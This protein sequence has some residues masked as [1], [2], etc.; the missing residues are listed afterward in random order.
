MRHNTVS[1]FAILRPV[2][3]VA[4]G[5]SGVSLKPRDP[6]S[7]AKARPI[8]LTIAVQLDVALAQVF[9]ALQRLCRQS[10]LAEIHPILTPVRPASEIFLAVVIEHLTQIMPRLLGALFMALTFIS[11]RG[12]TTAALISEDCFNLLTESRKF[13]SRSF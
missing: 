10:I 13:A 7:V 11:E 4:K 1:H 6:T 3:L 9:E 12:D 2:N 8:S 5:V